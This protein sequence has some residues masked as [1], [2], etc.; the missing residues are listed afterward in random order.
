MNLSKK[1]LDLLERCE[2][3]LEIEHYNRLAKELRTLRYKYNT[4]KCIS[5]YIESKEN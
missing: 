3:V 5:N 4:S 1:E 2:K